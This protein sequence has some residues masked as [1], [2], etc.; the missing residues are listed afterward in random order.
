MTGHLLNHHHTT[1]VQTKY[2]TSSVST[3]TVDT[4]MTRAFDVAVCQLMPS[5]SLPP[6]D[7]RCCRRLHVDSQQNLFLP[8]IHKRQ[9]MFAEVTVNVGWHRY[10]VRAGG[11]GTYVGKTEF[12]LGQYERKKPLGRHTP[13]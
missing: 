4:K 7:C 5:A 9:I 1:K 10:M 11:C 3:P 2:A 8:K 13:L 12:W 6:S